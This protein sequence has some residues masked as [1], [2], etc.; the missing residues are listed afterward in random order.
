MLS[1]TFFFSILI[2]GLASSLPGVLDRGV[3]GF[4]LPAAVA[5]RIAGTPPIGVLFAAFLGYNPMKSLIPAPVAQH[6]SAHAQRVLF[7]KQF[8]P[9]LILPAFM[10]GLHAAF[11]VSAALALIA[12]IASLLRGQRYI[13]GDDDAATATPPS[14]S[15]EQKEEQ[16]A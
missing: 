16:R 10:T 3:A 1:I 14:G 5:Q 7:G 15:D 6:L 2:A 13:H 12:A 4:G 9:H 8:F 11:Y